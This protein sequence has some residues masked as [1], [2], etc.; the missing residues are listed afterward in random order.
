MN[1]LEV[2]SELSKP[3]RILVFPCGS[4]IGLEVADSLKY[5][6]HFSLIGVSSQPDHGR[7]IFENYHEITS[8]IHEDSCIDE[9][10]EIIHSQEVD[11]VYPTMDLVLHRL[12]IYE[13]KLGVPVVSSPLE[14]TEIC[15][16]KKE[17]Y[18]HLNDVI[19]TPK[20]IN[21]DAQASEFP[22]FAKPDIG[23]GSRGTQL[24]SNP[25]DLKH[26]MESEK[27]SK[28]IIT[29]YLP[30][31]EYTV[32]CFSDKNGTL[33]FAG[34][35]ERGRISNGISVSSA[36]SSEL[37]ER[38]LP[39]AEAI[40]KKLTFRGAWFF[41]LKESKTLE[42]ALLEVACRLAGTSSV[43]RIQ[44]INF[45]ELS[46]YVALGKTV[47]IVHQNVS[48]KIDRA[49]SR[50][51]ELSVQ[52]EYVYIDLDDTLIVDNK[53]NS[54]LI[55]FIFECKNERKKI[56]LI[57][58]HAGNLDDTLSKFSL[59]PLFDE[60]IHLKKLDSKYE[61]IKHQASIFIDDSFSERKE[62]ADKLQ[63]LVFGPDDIAHLSFSKA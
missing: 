29:E 38:F 6:K 49:L 59:K 8:T 48:V 15:L 44:G 10:K 58:K 60:I 7:F 63:T 9:L 2:L 1:S 22:V 17:T 25:E 46:C 45:A 61:Y 21:I 33:L 35:R 5:N 16:S 14:T 36:T 32:D 41:Q 62:V 19:L 31:R 28:T 39:L 53:V 52:F 23:Y 56:I 47:S 30:G 34:A 55:K 26:F 51:F 40:N 3:Y 11:L 12:K 18:A 50:K 37:S 13:A 43:H 42:A 24:I 27:G 54:D 57:T 20:I 4:E